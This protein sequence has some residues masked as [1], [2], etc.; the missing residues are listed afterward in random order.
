MNTPSK[1]TETALQRLRNEENKGIE[2]YRSRGLEV[3]PQK[4]IAD[5]EIEQQKDLMLDELQDLIGDVRELLNLAMKCSKGSKG[6]ED[7]IKQ[8]L[9]LLQCKK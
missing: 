1:H 8:A 2:W 6:R 9:E 4:H 5:W 7:L 3:R